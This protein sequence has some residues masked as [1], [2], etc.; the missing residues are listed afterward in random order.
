MVTAENHPH[1]PR[2]TDMKAKIEL[3]YNNSG[4]SASITDEEGD[5]ITLVISRNNKDP[6]SVCEK[7]AARLRELADRYEKLG[8][9]VDPFK[10]EVQERINGASS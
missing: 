4:A 9:E 6:K 8:V 3:A 1:K 5:S 7:A 10:A 2:V